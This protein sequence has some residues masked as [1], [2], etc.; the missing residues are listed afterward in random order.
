MTTLH[1]DMSADFPD[2]PGVTVAGDSTSAAQKRLHRE[3]MAG[4]DAPANWSWTLGSEEHGSDSPDI[5]S[6]MYPCVGFWAASVWLL[7]RWRVILGTLCAAGVGYLWW[8]VVTFEPLTLWQ[9]GGGLCALFGSIVLFHTA[10]TAD[11]KEEA[12]HGR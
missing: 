3:T 5:D 10:A 4:N 8:P 11:A 9:I 2:V 6:V 7:N 1:D 12:N